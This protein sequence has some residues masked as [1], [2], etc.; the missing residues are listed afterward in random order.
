[1][2]QL[3]KT[4]PVIFLAQQKASDSSQYFDFR[5][6]DATRTKVVRRH[7]GTT[8]RCMLSGPFA[9]LSPAWARSAVHTARRSERRQH[10]LAPVVRSLVPTSNAPRPTAHSPHRC[11][12]LHLP[13]CA[14]AYLVSWFCSRTAHEGRHPS[15][16]FYVPSA[17]AWTCLAR[18]IKRAS[19]Y[20]LNR[21]QSNS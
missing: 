19:N 17:L 12:L 5:H 21:F 7:A 11:G 6:F 10:K 13:A 1:M 16:F 3:N 9:V 14:P 8:T 4:S 15:T 20:Q 2:Q 18:S